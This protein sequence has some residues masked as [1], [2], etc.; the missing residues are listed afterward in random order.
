MFDRVISGAA[1]R[2]ALIIAIMV[3]GFKAFI[4][5]FA[6]STI[7]GFAN[8]FV[9]YWDTANRPISLAYEQRPRYPFPYMPTMLL[10]LQPLSLVPVFPAY[11]AWVAI[12]ALTFTWATRKYLTMGQN[13]LA[14]ISR[15]VIFCLM[16]GQ[17]SVFL[18]AIMLTAFGT[19][20][21]YWAGIGLG[22]IASIKPQLVLL[23]PLL[24]LLRRDF[25]II[26]AAGATFTAIV[27]VALLAF[28]I[29]PW[30]D[31]LAS[32][33]NFRHILNTTQ[34]LRSGASPAGQAEWAGFPAWPFL[35]F[36]V[37]FGSW[38]I[39][40]CRNLGPLETTAAVT[41]ASIC[42]TPYAMVYDLA[43]V[44]PF[45]VVTIFRNRLTSVVALAFSAPPLPV[46]IAAFELLRSAKH[47][48]Q[49]EMAV[50]TTDRAFFAF[51]ARRC[52]DRDASRK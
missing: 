48:P 5:Y 36:G 30:L 43:A 17:V 4:L 29:D 32:L 39:Y 11:V 21:K 18:A 42:A 27:L 7:D 15:P 23:A 47:E 19:N 38:L 41:A 46:L 44:V 24:L 25:D 14:L 1:M 10:W 40:R 51:V 2:A 28:G 37:A 31:W 33:D 13:L 9:V 20:R 16:T 22:I 6:Y 8:D 12:S 35:I 34:I 45:L 52:V 50:R 3:C 26:V 49:N